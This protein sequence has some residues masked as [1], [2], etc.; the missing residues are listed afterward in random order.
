VGGGQVLDPDPPRA[1]V[2]TAAGVARFA[3]LAMPDTGHDDHAA[4]AWMV[5]EAGAAGVPAAALVAR[6]GVS[7]SRLS[8]A[9]ETLEQTGAV[10]ACGER[11]VAPPVLESL[12]A[13]VTALLAEYHRAQPLGDGMPRE[14]VRER[15]LAGA[16]TAVFEWVLARLVGAG[17]L[18]ARDRLAL[19]SHRLE[20][21]PEESRTLEAVARAYLEAGLA[22]PDLPAVSAATGSSPQ[23]VE[24][25]SALLLRR[26]ELVKVDT[27]IFHQAVLARLKEEMAGL[28]AA[29]GGEATVDVA[30]FKE[31]YGITRKFAIPLLEY[32]DRERVT[33]R[34]GDTRVLL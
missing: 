10:V 22:P 1:G 2:R 8:A 20:F 30:T 24:K 32:L 4:L 17:T 9:V 34:R 11:L 7:A 23:L 25:M 18:V 15:V 28:K 3:A 21:S 19:T 33:R 29:G 27:L 6:G 13:R 5:R 16:D 26:K 31:R 12:C 14:E